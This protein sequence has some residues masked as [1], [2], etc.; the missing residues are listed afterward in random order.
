MTVER[1][2]FQQECVRE[3]L[4]QLPG[5]ILNVGVNEDPAHLKRLDPD[6]VVNCDLFDHDTVMGRPNLVDRLFDAGVDPWPFDDD[7][8]ALVV[9]GDTMEHL[10]PAEQTH[11]LTEARR[12]ATRLCI[13]VPQDERE[14][15]NDETADGFPKGAVHRT[16]VTRALLRDL[17]DRTGWNPMVWRNVWYGF[18]PLGFF[19]LAEHTPDR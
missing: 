12:V 11:A 10:K 6:R 2:T 16:I 8:A 1:F 13:T 7:S 17:F 19:I 14:T 4:A 9:I 15:N 18:C 3:A 5:L